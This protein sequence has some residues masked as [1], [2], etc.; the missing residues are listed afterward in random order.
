MVP[1]ILLLF[2]LLLS[3]VSLPLPYLG[4]SRPCLVLIFVYYWSIYRPTLVPPVLCFALGI[5]MD[6]LSGGPLG[7]NALVLVA[8]QWVVRGQRRFLMGQPY[9]TTWAV[10][11][12]ILVFSALAQWGLYG[13]AHMQWPLLTPVA[14]SVALSLLLFP[15]I[16]FIFVMIHR[17]LPV[18]SRTLG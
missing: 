11:T 16:T 15:F 5:A 10:F 12:V 6:I 2:L 3:F 18:A 9:T 14:G 1:H 8:V 4:A 13:L 17:I 7:L